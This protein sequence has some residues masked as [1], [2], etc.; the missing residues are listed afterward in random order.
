MDFRYRVEI[1]ENTGW[2]T[3]LPASTVWD[4]CQFQVNS[5]IFTRYHHCLLNLL[6]DWESRETSQKWSCFLG[7]VW[8]LIIV[9]FEKFLWSRTQEFDLHT[10]SCM[11]LVLDKDFYESV[12]IKILA[13]SWLASSVCTVF[14]FLSHVVILFISNSD[15]RILFQRKNTLENQHWH[16]NSCKNPL[17]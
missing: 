12:A 15:M 13:Y 6:N 9:V 5:T 10:T 2:V 17:F 3:R 11:Q 7:W 1:N 4:Q 16:W 8:Y 14:F